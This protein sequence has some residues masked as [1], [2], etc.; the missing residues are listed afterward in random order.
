MKACFNC[1]KL[2]KLQEWNPRCSDNAEF[3]EFTPQLQQIILDAHNKLRNQQ[4]NGD[5]P[6]F[7]PAKRMATMV[8]DLW[9]SDLFVCLI[10][11]TKIHAFIRHGTM[12][13]PKLPN[14]TQ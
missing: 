13:W 1:I 12:N 7:E 8:M 3:I 2:S 14:T 4:A 11:L 9:H 10:N 5:T 6:G